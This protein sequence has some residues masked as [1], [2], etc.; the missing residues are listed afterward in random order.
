MQCIGLEDGITCHEHRAQPTG[1]C[2]LVTQPHRRHCVHKFC[3]FAFFV[4][5]SKCGGDALGERV[6]HH[7]CVHKFTMQW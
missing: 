5:M 3:I 1:T 6:N 4:C 2:G 7:C